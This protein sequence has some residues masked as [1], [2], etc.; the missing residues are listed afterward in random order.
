MSPTYFYHGIGDDIIPYENSQIV[1]NTFTG[2]GASN[3]NLILFPEALGGHSE[4]AIT[5]LLS[6]FETAL[7]Y[8]IINY[9]GDINNDGSIT[10]LDL[11]IIV[12]YLSSSFSIKSCAFAIS[13]AFT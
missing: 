10:F 3:V 5:C 4:V 11:T 7:D 2:N 1:Y 12:S 9:I 13:A 8:Q 6:G